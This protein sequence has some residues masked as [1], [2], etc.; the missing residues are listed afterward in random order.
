[1]GWIIQVTRVLYCIVVVFCVG[2]EREYL[3]L[4]DKRRDE[5]RRDKRRQEKTRVIAQMHHDPPCT[6]LPTITMKNSAE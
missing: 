1:M 2:L 4:Q 5:T 6:M 3:L